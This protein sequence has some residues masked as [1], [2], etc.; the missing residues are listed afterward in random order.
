MVV[1]FGQTIWDIAIQ[2]HGSI[3]GVFNLMADNADQIKNLNTKLK[4]GMILKI[5][6]EPADKSVRDHY[7]SHR[8]LPVSGVGDLGDYNNDFNHDFFK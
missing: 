8:L 5:K 4:A 1:G 6:S 7:S 3:E 2:E